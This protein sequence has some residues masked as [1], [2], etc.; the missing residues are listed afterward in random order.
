[1]KMNIIFIIMRTPL[2]AAA[3]VALLPAAA[4]AGRPTEGPTPQGSGYRP[5][6]AVQSFASPGGHVRVHF[7][8]QSID[9][10]PATDAEP[11]DGVPDLVTLVART[12]D[13]AWE[14]L[15]GRGFRLP[16]DDATRHD[17]TD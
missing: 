17:G 1:M 9:A 13:Q 8:L 2:L 4:Q 16:L 12:A 11:P 10:V 15:A 5:G 3:A 14:S 6:V 7:T